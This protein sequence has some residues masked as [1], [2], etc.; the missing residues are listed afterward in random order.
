LAIPGYTFGG[1]SKTPG[2]TTPITS[3]GPINT[4]ENLYAIW[5]PT[6]SGVM[7]NPQTHQSPFNTPYSGTL[8]VAG[9]SSGDYYLVAE[10]SCGTV[11]VNA[12]GSYSLKPNQNFTGSCTFSYLLK[13]SAGSA[14]STATVIIST[15]SLASTGLNVSVLAIVAGVLLSIGGG[16]VIARRRTHR[17][18][19]SAR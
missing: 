4:D 19:G 10:P 16:L 9:N 2:G 5:V 14:I 7:A 1:W 3:V 17:A 18:Q 12:N 6:H 13:G 15:A 8:A 11:T